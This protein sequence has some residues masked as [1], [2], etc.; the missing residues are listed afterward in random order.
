MIPTPVCRIDLY[1]ANHIGLNLFIYRLIE[2]TFLLYKI[3][4]RLLRYINIIVWVVLFIYYLLGWIALQ[5][6]CNLNKIR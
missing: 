3:E 4:I 1:Q 6:K 2:A 5:V